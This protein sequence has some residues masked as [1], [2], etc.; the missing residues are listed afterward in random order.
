MKS[1]LNSGTSEGVR[2]AW[3]TRKTGAYADMRCAN[4]SRDAERQSEL[5]NA[6][7]SPTAHKR[8]AKAHREAETVWKNRHAA[9]GNTAHGVRSRLHA[10][11]AEKHEKAAAAKA[12]GVGMLRGYSTGPTATTSET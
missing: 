8:A 2:R 3:Q 7:Q 11:R 1:L 5:A 9:S 12:S 4:C 10:M 6:S